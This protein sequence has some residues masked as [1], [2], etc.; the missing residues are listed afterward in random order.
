MRLDRIA[1][2][3]SVE[4]RE[5]FLDHELVEFALALPP[6]LKYRDGHGKHV[7]A[8]GGARRAPAGDPR[9][10]QAGLRHADGGVAARRLRRRGRRRRCAARRWRERG[11]LDYDAGRQGCSPPTAPGAATGA[12][13]CGTSTASAA[14][15]TGGSQ[16][17][18]SP[19]ADSAASCD[20]VLDGCLEGVGH[21]AVG[22]ARDILSGLVAEALLAPDPRRAG[23][24]QPP[25]Q[26]GRP[27]GPR[28]RRGR[29]H[30]PT[31][32][33]ADRIG[34]HHRQAGVH[35]PL[36]TSPDGSWSRSVVIEGSTRHRERASSAGRS[37]GYVPTSS[38]RGSCAHDGQPAALASRCR[39][40]AAS[41]A[42]R[43][44]VRRPPADAPG[45]CV[46]ELTDEEDLRVSDSAGST[47]ANRPSFDRLVGM[48]DL[49]G[50]R[51]TCP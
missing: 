8:R 20:R 50:R 49:A 25:A 51:P 26:K 24:A 41:R 17:T 40:A 13:T 48:I 15:T 37:F 19:Q 7:A 5:P 38:T 9:P 34:G 32:R 44:G 27:R 45:P 29:P 10:A 6:E 28:S 1:M 47:A 12:S 30:E 43:L 33:R 3:S 16:R 2:A 46:L 21:C 11:L 36:T 18:R 31:G 42:S 35:G 23:L 4:G 14:G 22:E 39:S